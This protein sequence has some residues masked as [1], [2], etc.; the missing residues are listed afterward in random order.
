MAEKQTNQKS[1]RPERR[2]VTSRDKSGRGREAP[3]K[4]FDS[5]AWKPRTG[6]GL[7][8]KSGEITKMDEILDSNK[9]VLES[10]IVD[11]LLPDASV[12]LLM[13]GQAK[14]KFGGGQRRVFRQTQK[15]TNEGNK[16]SFATFVVVGNENGYVGV[17]YGKSRET[18]PAREKAIRNAKMNI[19]KIT[20]GCGSWQCG[21]GEPHTIPF[22]IS[23]KCGS[24]TLKLM[25][26]PKGTG[27][28]V[29]K[30]CQKILATAGIKD[31]W[32]HSVGRTRTKI[33]LLKACINA[34][35]N[36]SSTRA[37]QKHFKA[38]GMV[39]GMVEKKEEPIVEVENE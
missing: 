24:V 36:L 17:G 16:P 21:C 2:R 7:K 11:M 35:S 6:M 33:N 22:N 31:V 37:Q 3:K 14:G 19:I 27:L 18:V 30:E 8:V 26:A 39:D 34:L 9:K 10:E 38:L 28:C 5:E 13:I 20:R 25:P 15:K 12:D 1:R 32:S 4:V 23:G 29:E